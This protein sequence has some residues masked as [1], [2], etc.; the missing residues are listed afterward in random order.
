ALLAGA[1]AA[2]IA[3]LLAL[4][5]PAL[6]AAAAEFLAA[7]IIRRVPRPPAG[8]Q[9]GVVSSVYEQNLAYRAH[10]AIRSAGRLAAGHSSEERE[11]RFY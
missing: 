4:A 8:T 9:W 1:S 6:E 10:F 7:L 2:A 3:S 5:A 11:Q